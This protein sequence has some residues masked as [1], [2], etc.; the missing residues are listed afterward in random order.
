MEHKA[1]LTSK[2]QVTIPVEVRR[3]LSL[4]QGDTLAFVT[5]GDR[6]VVRRVA[7]GDPF[8]AYSGRYR[9]GEGKSREAINREL[10]DLRGE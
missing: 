9:V 5:E 6:I 1:T 8:A 10:R 2:G 4:R 3:A 7:A